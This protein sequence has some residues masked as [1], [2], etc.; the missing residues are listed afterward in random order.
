MAKKTR[1][2]YQREKEMQAREDLIRASHD[3]GHSAKAALE[4]EEA[5]R[6]GDDWQP[7]SASNVPWWFSLILVVAVLGLLAYF[8]LPHTT[9]FD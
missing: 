2:D 6:A 8:V 4:V 1:E 5:R 3:I 7:D 9:I